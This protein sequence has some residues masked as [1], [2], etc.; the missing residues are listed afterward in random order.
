MC[1]TCVRVVVARNMY[2]LFERESRDR[3][4]EREGEGGR[5]GGRD[6]RLSIVEYVDTWIYTHNSR[7]NVVILLHLFP[8]QKLSSKMRFP[9]EGSLLSPPLSTLRT[10]RQRSPK[11]PL[12]GYA[13]LV[14][15][16][17]ANLDSS[18]FG[19]P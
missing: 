11:L 5:E 7:D 1:V 16:L 18:L 13:V 8:T 2:T 6:V 17:S 10:S 4:T 9:L 3:E 19:S 15:P 12:T 14:C